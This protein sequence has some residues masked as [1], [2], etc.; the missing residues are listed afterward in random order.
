VVIT[1]VVVEPQ[2]D[3]LMRVR[4]LWRRHS[5]TLGF[6]PVGAFDDY[7]SKRC[8]LAAVDA[9]GVLLGYTLFRITHRRQAMIAHLCVDPEVRG[10]GTARHLFD[11][12]KPLV[13]NC[14]D[15]L[16]R[17]RRDFAASALWPRLGFVSVGEQVGR[18][19]TAQVV[20]I[21]RYELNRL[22]LLAAMNRPRDD[23][24]PVV[25]DANVFFDLD[26]AAGT[27]THEESQSLLADWLGGFIELCVTEEIYNEIDRHEDP[28]NRERQRTRA[29]Q[30]RRLPTDKIR[31]E[32]ALT[33]L[34]D[35][36][37][38]WTS[39]SERS[40]ARQL[41]RAIAGG[42]TFF[43]TR[44]GPIR[45]E[46]DKIYDRF[47]LVIVSPFELVL[48]FDELRREDAYRPRR[49]ISSGLKKGKP[50]GI[51]DLERIA[52]LWGVGQPSPEPRRRTLARLR[53]MS[54]DPERYEFSCITDNDE[55]FLAVYAIERPKPD[56][57]RI[58]IFAVADSTI[59]R[60]AARHF[61]EKLTML[62]ASEARV[63]IAVQECAG[64]KRIE[65]A[66]SD[67]GFMKDGAHF[68]KLALP[69]VA[70]AI[71]LALELDLVGSRHVEARNV[72]TWAAAH[73][74]SGGD[75]FPPR[76]E[77]LPHVERALWPAKILGTALPCYI[78]PIRPHWAE[79]LFDIEL[80]RHS[81]FGADPRLAMNS[82]NAY[83]RA[84]RPA[85][86]NAPARLLWYVSQDPAY[87]GAKAIRA[88]S[89][90]DEVLVAP[91]K[92]AFRRF[93]RLGVYRW[94][95]VFRVAKSD[96]TKDVMAFRFSKTELFSR[97][98]AWEILQ[99]ELGRAGGKG[100]QLQS[101]LQISESCF[102][103]LYKLGMGQA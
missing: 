40:D 81:L 56:V 27:V 49:F 87:P 95:D 13:S 62:A 68:I 23:V 39:D 57:L 24:V 100:S 8:I 47:E 77:I 78:V 43:V 86:L 51:D 38:T 80:A 79:Q 2:T 29:E 53:D 64:G 66:L 20:T 76:P 6:F 85:I 103:E 70:R 67:A 90:L 84:A 94:A 26:G 41:A 36:F 73:L 75:C 74:R 3:L 96:L 48:R 92:D 91:P 82:E 60:T 15:I 37:P 11:A 99:T 89:Y 32:K 5:D 22:P 25:I 63:V 7:A 9:D 59:G 18:G 34:E 83:Y 14:D 16:V 1:V 50:R 71:D 101:P 52:D 55:T 97:P 28:S 72:A 45:D 69:C 30:F 61:T 4:N 65:E 98:V 58:P 21:W 93:Q 10:R 31:E 46:A 102:L 35:L 44:D 42:A 54:S 88:C 19:R 17:C 12:L 33:E